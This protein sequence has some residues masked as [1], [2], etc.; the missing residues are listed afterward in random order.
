[1]K[2]AK[3]NEIFKEGKTMIIA[4]DQ[5]FEHGPTSDFNEKNVDPN[6]IMDIALEGRY[7]CV[8]VQSGIAEKYYFTHYREVPLLVKLNAKTRFDSKEPVSLQHTSVK[9]AVELGA[10]A[11]GY[12]IYLGSDYEQK[13]F[14]EFGKIVEDAHTAGIPVICWMYPRGNHIKDETSVETIAYGVRVAMELGADVIKTKFVDDMQGLKWIRKCAGRSKLV[15]A[16][17]SKQG[18]LDFLKMVEKVIHAGFDG[19]AVGRNVWQSEHPLEITKGLKEIIF[20]GKSAEEAF[21]KMK[22]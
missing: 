12:T 10:K 18:D 2:H 16:G 3:L 14:K 13:M 4:Y 17:G 22:K 7:N 19:I 8:A 5:G 20:K 9:Y 15:L 21:S 6:Y 11:V 1:M